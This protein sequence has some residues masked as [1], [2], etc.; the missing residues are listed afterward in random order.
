MKTLI[1]CQSVAHGNTLKIA[2]IIAEVLNAEIMKPQ[3]VTQQTI[4]NFDIIGFG[5]GI[6]F[7]NFHKSLIKLLDQLDEV[8]DKPSFIF[9]TSGLREIPLINNFN[10]KF[11]KILREKGFKIIGKFSCR[12][13]DNW[14]LLKLIG[15][16]HKNRPNKTD[17]K[18]AKL[19]AENIKKL[20]IN[21]S[22]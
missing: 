11:E 20:T 5:S 3:Q 1:I 17:L 14:G 12:G 15:G 7:G 4:K 6:F 21:T 8:N 18:K 13:F 22:N 10:K 19:F 16:I 2:K 9:S